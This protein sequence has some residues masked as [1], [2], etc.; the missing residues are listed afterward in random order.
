MRAVRA[1]T[2]DLDDTLWEIGPVIARAE[3]KV[4]EEIRNRFPRVAEH[5]AVEGIQKT[6]QQVLRKHPE[7]AHDLTEIRRVTFRWMLTGCD[8]NPDDS[9]ALLEQFLQLRHEVEFFADV[10]PALRRLSERYPLL[11]MTNGNADVE[12]L[13]ITHFFTGH[14]SARSAGVLKPDPRI[15]ELA[16]QMLEEDPGAVLHVGDHP[17]DD[18]LGALDAGFQA[19]WINRRADIWTHER[20]PH[21]EVQN[22]IELVDLLDAEN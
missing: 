13:G 5:Y 20:E 18:V 17:V 16:C 14:I 11:T 15:F 1:I 22:L 8:Y 7:I 2:F 12:R 3:R 6:R 4:Y 10:V 9:H 21:A 19:A